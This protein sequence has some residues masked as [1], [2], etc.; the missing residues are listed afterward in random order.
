MKSGYRIILIIWTIMMITLSSVPGLSPPP[1]LPTTSD[2]VVHFIEYAIWAFL[3]LSMLKQEN[4]IDNVW[5]SF[6]TTLLLG[7]IFG[8]L[9]EIHQ[10]FIPGR[11]RDMLDL[12]AD[13]GG[14]LLTSVIF[15]LVY[16]IKDGRMR[17]QKLNSSRRSLEQTKN[18][19]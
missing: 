10:G 2:K 14:L 6:R 17:R 16:Q 1:G 7:V 18:V 11:E 3:F 19:D 5:N 12:L 9:D 13:F 4:R 8:L 15:S